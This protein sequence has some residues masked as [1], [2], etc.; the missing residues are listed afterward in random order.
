MSRTSKSA[1]SGA[2]AAGSRAYHH[3]DLKQALLKTSVKIIEKEGVAGLTLQKAARQQGV[4]AAAVYRHYGSKEDLLAA[5]ATEGFRL[6]RD[7]VQAVIADRPRDTRAFFRRSMEKYIDLAIS[8]PK[9][10]ELMFGGTIPD[11]SPY[12]ELEAVGQEAFDG[13]IET[14]RICQNEGLF[15]KRKPVLMAFHVWSLMH[16]FVMLHIAGH[17]PFPTDQPEQLRRLTGLLNQFLRRG[18]D[19]S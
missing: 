14:V 8:K 6:L 19:R 18:L 5:I 1:K 11:R 10:Y 12:A 2:A 9:H 4:S 7:G 3:G 17:T 16:G 15:K 13:L